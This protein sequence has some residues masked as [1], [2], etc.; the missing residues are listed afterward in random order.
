MDL[1]DFM[2]H[3]TDVLALPAGQTLF[4]EGDKGDS[5]YVLVS[6]HADV[7]LRGK[8]VEQLESGAIFGELAII[9]NTPRAATIVARDD[10]NFIAINAGRFRTLTRENPDFALH[11]MRA[12]ADRLRHVGKLL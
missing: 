7:L 9:D 12:M 10:C 8:V 11:V 6:G 3:Q 1:E 5:M 2:L 4:A